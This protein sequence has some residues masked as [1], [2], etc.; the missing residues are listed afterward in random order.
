MLCAGKSESLSFQAS[1]SRSSWLIP[2]AT[3]WFLLQANPSFSNDS[4]VLPVQITSCCRVYLF[5]LAR[6][7][8]STSSTSGTSALHCD[9]LFHITAASGY[10]PRRY[11]DGNMSA[12]GSTTAGQELRQAGENLIHPL[13]EQG[14]DLLRVAEFACPS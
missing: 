9:E 1:D 12:G 8:R 3:E 10:S 13:L 14:K 4:T 6:E 2:V 7:P 5:G 11:E